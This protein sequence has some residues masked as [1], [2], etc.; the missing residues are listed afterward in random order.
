MCAKVAGRLNLGGYAGMNG[1]T[2]EDKSYLGPFL[3][4]SVLPGDEV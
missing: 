2:I 1:R 4:A 3:S